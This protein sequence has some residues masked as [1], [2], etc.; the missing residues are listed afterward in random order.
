MTR[1]HGRA[2]RS[3]LDDDWRHGST[4]IGL[5]DRAGPPSTGLPRWPPYDR[6]STNGEDARS[7]R[8]SAAH[9]RR[10]AVR[11]SRWSTCSPRSSSSA[12]ALGATTEISVTIAT[13][14]Q[15]L[16]ALVGATLIAGAAAGPVVA[17]PFVAVG[18][19]P[20]ARRRLIVG[21]AA[22]AV[23]GILVGGGILVTFGASG[24]VGVLAATL[25]VAAVLGGLTGGP[26]AAGA[27]R[28]PR[29]RG[30]LP[31]GGD[32]HQPLP[33]PA[34][35]RARRRTRRRAT[36]SPGRSGCSASR[37]GDPGHRGRGRRVPVPA[38]ARRRSG[39]AVVPARR[40]RLGWSAWPR[41]AISRVGGFS[42]YRL[43]E[44]LLSPMTP[45]T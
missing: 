1:V 29:R 12:A 11:R 36:G 30:G 8:R 26:P 43:V 23:V 16:P 15:A 24:G 40:R 4:R 32:P 45:P 38:R 35:D 41:I 17:D 14:A 2:P 44:R 13:V 42:L 10:P 27:R 5:C 22:G 21:A 19:R 3:G 7:G 18:G 33:E 20:G 6:H 28:R 37:V 39:L 31:A 9:R 34:H 25:L